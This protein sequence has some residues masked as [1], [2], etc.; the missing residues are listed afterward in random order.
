MEQY[1]DRGYLQEDFRLF[2][3]R[4]QVSLR[5]IEF[6]YHSFHKLLFFVSGSAAYVV[7]GKHYQLEPGDVVLVEQ[8][9]VHRPEVGLGLP[10]ERFV[11]Y[12]SSGFVS[13]CSRQD[14]DLSR[15]FRL[16]HDRS[17]Y[18]LRPGSGERERL[19][20]LFT[21]LEQA[22]DGDGYGSGLLARLLVQEL[23]IHLARLAEAP[24]P[25]PVRAV[26]DEK[27]VQVLKYLSD[28]LT[29]PLH[30]DRLAAEFYV[31]KYHLM[32]RFKAETGYT[33][34]QYLMGKR[35]FYARELLA[36]GENASQVCYQCG[37]QDYSAFARA[38]K[39]QFGCPPSAP[40]EE[41][42]RWI[43]TAL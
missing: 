9:S 17:D 33:I 34:H 3:I 30:I 27:I 16:A 39:K 20:E 12:L 21:R 15:C 31:S 41:N 19:A 42:P 7:E 29:Q 40:A 43:L 4:D 28:H 37:Y 35:L 26:Y 6:H 36:R 8:G 13:R 14:C 24:G 11:L 25:A 32:R 10:Y 23:L 2:H 22:G 1:A 5:E 18:I 38:Y